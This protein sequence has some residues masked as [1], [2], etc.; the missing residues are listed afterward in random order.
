MSEFPRAPDDLPV[1][2]MAWL[3]ALSAHPELM[4][5]LIGSLSVPVLDADALVDLM[6]RAAS[7][8]VRTLDGV[9]WAG[10]TAEFEGRPPVTAAHTA[11]RVLVVDERQYEILDGPCLQALRLD[12]RVEVGQQELR[13]R[14]PR[15]A[16]RAE[17]VGVRSILALPLHDRVG[18][19]I[20]SFNL[21]SAGVVAPPVDED[22]LTVLTGYL[23]RGLHRYAFRYGGTEEQLRAALDRQA[24]VEQAV[25]ILMA[26][27]H[28]D[29][30]QA[31]DRLRQQARETRLSLA[32]LARSIVDRHRGS[33]D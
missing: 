17:A 6:A 32:E 3:R 28:S 13:R 25:G 2:S 33:S 8:A 1:P 29:Q 22:I 5:D 19:A 16:D 10:V 24:A 23:D 9:D 30:I 27:H 7:A 15:L 14:W 21:Y 31:R 4:A 18:S 20:G 12:Q 11:Q 26:L